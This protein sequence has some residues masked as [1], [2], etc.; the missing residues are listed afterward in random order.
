MRSTKKLVTLSL[1][2]LVLATV[3]FTLA[4]CFLTPDG[5]QHSYVDEVVAPTCTEKGYTK[6]TCS[7]GD[8]YTDNETPAAH[9]MQQVA[10]KNPTCSEAGVEAHLA[11][12]LCGYVDGEKVTGKACFILWPI[13]RFGTPNTTLTE[14][15]AGE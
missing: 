15:G 5:H 2:V 7:C 13:A 9:K 4:A 1:T 10:R 8:S 3:L 11:C 14:G 6:H 12:S